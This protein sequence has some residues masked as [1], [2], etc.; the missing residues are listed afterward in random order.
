MSWFVLSIATGVGII[1]G[2]VIRLVYAK[3]QLRSAEKQAKII[4]EE[5][6]REAKTKV[7]EGTL[8]I[9]EKMQKARMEFESETRRRRHEIERLE[10]VSKSKEETLGKRAIELDYREKEIEKKLRFIAGKEKWIEE[11]ERKLV[12]GKEEQKKVLE[13]LAHMTPE[14]A[15]NILLENMKE[16]AQR[17]AQVLAKRVEEEAIENAQRKARQILSIAIQRCSAEY[18]EEVTV[19]SVPLP[20]DEMKGRVIGREGRNIHAFETA[21]GVDLI[22]DDT[23]EAITLSAFDGVRREIARIALERLITDGRIHPT[24]I[25]EVVEKVK[26]EMNQHLKEVGEDA[27][28]KLGLERVSQE[29]I[30]MIGRLKYRTSYGQNVLQ[31]SIE[32]AKAAAILTEEVGGDVKFAKRAGLLHDIGKAIDRDVEGTHAQIGA[33]LLK[34]HGESEK[35]VN[36][37]LCHHG[38][39][40]PQSIEAVLLQAADAISASRPGARRETLEFYI[41]RLEKLEKI[42]NSFRGVEKAYAIQAGREVRIIVEPEEVDD[43][44]AQQL[45]REVAKKIQQEVKYPGQVKV[46][47]IRE[48][49]STEVAK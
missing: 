49:R 40:E 4:L 29:L 17:E 16:D 36:A 42:A 1:V 9:K 14:E 43:N 37:I 28:L 32:V 41:K 2:Y 34:K 31:H 19:T 39:C 21:T 47:V 45:A 22:V 26:K 35:V 18:T 11:E 33:D 20:N 23:P 13:R 44:L 24:R 30:T 46:T 6:E 27:V 15:K 7:K 3:N 12:K 25:E 8:E 38:D 48:T 5:A 10:K